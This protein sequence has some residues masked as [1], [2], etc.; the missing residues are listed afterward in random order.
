M[1]DDYTTAKNIRNYI[2]RRSAEVMNY[3]WDDK[4]SAEY[5]KK[6]PEIVQKELGLKTVDVSKF[7]SEQMDDLG[8]GRWEENNPMRLIPLWLFQFLPE[9]IET[10]DINGKTEI[11]KKSEMDNDHRFGCLAYGIIPQDYHSVELVEE[12]E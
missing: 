4:Y 5:I 3:S 10:K 11:L 1:S 7:T 9:E 6:I 12:I 2:V 8:F